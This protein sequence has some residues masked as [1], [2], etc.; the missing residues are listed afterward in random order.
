MARVSKHML[1]MAL[2]LVFSPAVADWNLESNGRSG[3]F[4]EDVNRHQLS[5]VENRDSVDF[6]LSLKNGEIGANPDHAVIR[7]RGLREKSGKLDLVDTRPGRRTYLIELDRAQKTRLINRMIG[8]LVITIDI[9]TPSTESLGV[10]FSLAG[11]T[12]SLNDFLILREIG[13]LDYQRLF[14][15]G[16]NQELLCLYAGDIYVRS[17]LARY[18]NLSL[19]QMLASI[20]KTGIEMLD[21]VTGEMVDNVF[22]IPANRLPRDPRAEKYGIFKACLERAG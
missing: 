1:G 4:T 2:A 17:V 10:E 8:E 13:S 18:A 14:D 21:A 9:V 16:K 3:I 22:G 6:F 20:P 7:L 5:I 11:F 15:K 19:A 12:A